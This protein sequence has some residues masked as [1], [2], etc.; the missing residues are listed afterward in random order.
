MP[1]FVCAKRKP[2]TKT[3]TKT[4]DTSSDDRSTISHANARPYV[5]TN[6]S[7]PGPNSSSNG[8]A[9]NR[10]DPSA[11]EN[12]RDEHLEEQQPVCSLV[13]DLDETNSKNTVSKGSCDSFP[14]VSQMEYY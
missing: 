12:A 14:S 8:R 10:A 2:D 7:D 3:H 1:V 4:H 11:G 5:Y 6:T 9:D 13:C